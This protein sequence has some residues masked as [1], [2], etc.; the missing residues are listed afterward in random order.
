ML[1]VHQLSDVTSA[2]IYQ[3]ARNGEPIARQV[4]K[5]MGSHA[6]HRHREPDQ[7]L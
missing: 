5:D 3:A 2:Q 6:R 4:M 7:Y 1:E